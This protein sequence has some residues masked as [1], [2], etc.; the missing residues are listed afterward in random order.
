MHEGED[1]KSAI[2]YDETFKYL[3]IFFFWNRI[4][5]DPNYSRLVGTSLTV[6]LKCFDSEGQK[7]E[8]FTRLFNSTPQ[9]NLFNIN[10]IEII[11]TPRESG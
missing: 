1:L 4:S 9:V 11:H 5:L 7:F 3:E 6:I 10:S 2:R 8:I